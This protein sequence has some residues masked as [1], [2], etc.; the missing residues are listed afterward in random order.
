MENMYEKDMK[1]DYMDWK[2]AGH[3]TWHD[4]ILFSYKLMFLHWNGEQKVFSKPWIPDLG[5]KKKIMKEAEFR[6]STR[7]STWF[8]NTLPGIGN[9]LDSF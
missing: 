8:F 5:E 1:H 9:N 3:R 7:K 6:I 4:T 2:I